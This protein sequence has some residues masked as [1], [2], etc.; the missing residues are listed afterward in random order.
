LQTGI[1]G[2]IC[3]HNR[4]GS[5]GRI[6]KQFEYTLISPNGQPSQDRAFAVPLRQKLDNMG[7]QPTPLLRLNLCREDQKQQ[8]SYGCQKQDYGDPAAHQVTG[9]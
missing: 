9:S 6:Q 5:F 8:H 4:P 1:S 7:V 3:E 2:L